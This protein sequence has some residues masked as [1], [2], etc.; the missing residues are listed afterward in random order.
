MDFQFRA[1]VNH[2]WVL[3]QPCT[4]QKDFTFRQP[5][6][7]NLRTFMTF[8][9]RLAQMTS[10]FRHNSWIFNFVSQLIKIEFWSHLAP[11]KRILRFDNRNYGTFELLWHFGQTMPFFRRTGWIFNFVPQLI[12]I[13][14]W[15][16]LVP[17]KRILRFDNRNY[18]TF[19]ESS[20]F[21][22]KVPFYEGAK[23]ALIRL[24]APNSGRFI[25]WVQGKASQCPKSLSRHPRNPFGTH[26][27]L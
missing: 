9:P 7:R 11:C 20:W 26:L 13:E 24:D 16:N 3:T 6:L 27:F 8:L 25:P 17:H 10:I 15:P 14:F 19:D 21:F 1:T 23:L 5:E 12:M 18:G 22:K 4:T 2:N